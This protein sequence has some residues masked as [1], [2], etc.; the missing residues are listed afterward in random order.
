[1]KAFCEWVEKGFNAFHSKALFSSNPRSWRFW[2]RGPKKDM[3]ICGLAK[4]SSDSVG[5]PFPLLIAGI[6][7]LKGW[8]E[9]WD[10]LPYACEE[11]WS[12][13]EYLSAKR[14]GDFKEF[15]GEIGRVNSP[16]GNWS[17]LVAQR[18]NP[19]GWDCGP[20]EGKVMGLGKESSS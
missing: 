13:M 7:L 4:D 3:L 19:D 12:H 16:G 17:E 11:T 1:M 10:L 18:P 2:A 6:G 15:E 8:G 5:R 9:A 20:L 14:F